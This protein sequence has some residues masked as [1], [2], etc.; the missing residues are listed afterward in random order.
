MNIGM[1]K[2]DKKVLANMTENI[3]HNL[4]EGALK[5]GDTIPLAYSGG[6]ISETLDESQ[7]MAPIYD[8]LTLPPNYKKDLRKYYE[9]VVE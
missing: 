8:M 6:L 2:W 1:E 5:I 9:R 4:K 3:K 7:L